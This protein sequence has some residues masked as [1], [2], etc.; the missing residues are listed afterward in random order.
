MASTSDILPGCVQGAS[1]FSQPVH[2][3]R[4][5]ETGNAETREAPSSLKMLSNLCY[6]RYSLLN[7]QYSS[8]ILR[9]YKINHAG[10][11]V[12]DAAIHRKRQSIASTRNNSVYH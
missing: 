7:N 12:Q 6:V 11:Q 3:A 10:N 1:F 8:W 9:I 2:G 5:D 4:N